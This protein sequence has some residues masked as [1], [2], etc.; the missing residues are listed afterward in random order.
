MT[1]EISDPTE[2][3]G[4]DIC[5]LTASKPLFMFQSFFPSLEKR[6]KVQF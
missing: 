5:L 4:R 3:K 1:M 2:I 6:M